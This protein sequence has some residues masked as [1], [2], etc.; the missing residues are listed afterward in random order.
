MANFGLSKPWVAQY[1]S[2]GN[3]KSAFRCAEAVNTSVNPS[4]NEASLRGDN[5]EVENVKEFKNAAVNLGVTRLPKVAAKVML[6]HTVGEDGTETSNT[7]D[8]TGY[9]GYGFITAE[10]EDGKK[11]YRA[12]FLPKVK[13]AEGEESYET[14]GDSIAFKT[15]TLSGT[16]IGDEDGTWRI[17]S[18]HYDTEEEADKW[19]QVQVGVLTQCAAPVASVAGGS[20]E[21]A[22][23]VTLSTSIQGA[24]IRYTTDGTTPSETNGTV[25][26]KAIN[27]SGNTGLRAIAYKEGAQTSGIMLEEYFITAN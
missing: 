12:C 3:Y 25:Y 21:G 23:S 8:F 22:Q 27:I 26:S 20:Y 14:K 11:T 15:P 5:R 17:K 10:M 18:P 19:I 6:G 1:V 13:F 24:T 16:A 7:E 9:V 4:Y 2:R